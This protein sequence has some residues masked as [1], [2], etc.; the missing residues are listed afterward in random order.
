MFHLELIKN[1]KAIWRLLNKKRKFCLE[2]ELYC[3]L[4]NS[5]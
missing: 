5:W 4:E 1:Y 3:V 2:R